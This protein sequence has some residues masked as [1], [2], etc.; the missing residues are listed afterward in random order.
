MQNLLFFIPQIIMFVCFGQ[1]V[2]ASKICLTSLCI[3]RQLPPPGF[4]SLS[5]S[6][7]CEETSLFPFPRPRRLP[8]PIFIV[9]W[10]NFPQIFVHFFK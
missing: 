4:A 7:L 9:F 8:H 10:G 5:G 1:S 3:N 6:T 2:Y